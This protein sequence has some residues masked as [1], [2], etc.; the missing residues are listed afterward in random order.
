MSKFLKIIITTMIL[1]PI[2]YMVFWSFTDILPWPK[3]IPDGINLDVWKQLI[4]SKDYIRTIGVSIVVSMWTAAICILVALPTAYAITCFD[5]CWK[6]VIRGIVYLPFF[7]PSISLS[8]GLH[9]AFL[10]AGITDSIMGVVLSHIVPCL[11]YTIMILEGSFEQMGRSFSEQGRNLGAN[12]IQLLTMVYLPNMRQ[13]L[14]L[15]ASMSFIVS[16]SQ[17]LLTFLVGGGIIKT[18]PVMLFQIMQNG[19]RTEISAYS[20]G[21]IILG[22]ICTYLI[23]KYLG[24]R[25]IMKYM[26]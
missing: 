15:S 16:F 10:T 13:A 3:L 6:P 26:L 20:L 11:P 8:L 1:I 25:Y 9:S 17:Y 12:S 4:S 14:Y 24:E 5:F 7:I 23:R 18:L 22:A 2:L 21:F 19:N